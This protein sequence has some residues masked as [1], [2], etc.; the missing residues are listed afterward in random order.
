MPGQALLS[1]TG[2]ILLII[3]PKANYLW[4]PD[5]GQLK[6]YMNR[7]GALLPL[8]AFIALAAALASASTPLPNS[9]GGKTP[10]PAPHAQFL[11]SPPAATV[12]IDQRHL[13]TVN[14]IKGLVLTCI[15]PELD[16]NVDTDVFKSCTLAPGRTLD[17]VMHV[18][19][20]G[21]HFEQ[22]QHEKERAEWQKDLAQKAAQ[23]AA[24][25]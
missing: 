10:E 5:P 2:C 13:F 8:A 21:I 19:I 11:K 18:F 12:P 24:S 17:D 16:K 20:Q 3:H 15:A 4:N 22:N 7:P 9:Q 23:T 25:K 1:I 6:V 14:D